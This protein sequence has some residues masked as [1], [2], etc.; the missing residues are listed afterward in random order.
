MDQSLEH[1]VLLLQTQAE[2]ADIGYNHN[3]C[4]SYI[5]HLTRPSKLGIWNF[6]TEGRHENKLLH[7][8]QVTLTQ[9][10]AEL[11]TG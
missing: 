7:E 6:T 11:K 4:A 10:W 5:R 2:A 9:S 8:K 3:K 1:E